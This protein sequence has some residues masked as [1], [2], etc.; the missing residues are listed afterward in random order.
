[1]AA[2]QGYAETRHDPS[3]WSLQ[4]AGAQGPGSQSS[5]GQGLAWHPRCCPSQTMA[6]CSCPHKRHSSFKLL[7]LH[8]HPVS[9]SK[10]SATEETGLLHVLC[11]PG[12]WIW[13]GSHALAQPAVPFLPPTIS[14][15]ISGPF[16]PSNRTSHALTPHQAPPP[17]LTMRS[18]AELGLCAKGSLLPAP[19][20]V[21]SRLRGV[22]LSGIL[23]TPSWEEK[24]PAC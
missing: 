11:M 23:N 22:G 17:S 7:P 18:G 9:P 14:C 21:C 19:S 8:L 16:Q 10:E 2:E 4:L 12:A 1:M 6:V 5:T 13:R 24:R 3:S 20:E 15:K